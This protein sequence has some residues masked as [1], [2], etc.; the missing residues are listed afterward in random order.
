MLRSASRMLFFALLL[1]GM[2]FPAVCSQGSTSVPLAGAQ[3]TAEQG[4]PA[5]V[6]LPPNVFAANAMDPGVP[7]PVPLPPGSSTGNMIDPGV[8]APVPLP[9]SA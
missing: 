9:P 8:P 3:R 4:V 5:P 2:S 6:P 7:A 1:A